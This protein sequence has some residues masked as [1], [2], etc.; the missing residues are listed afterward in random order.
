MVPWRQGTRGLS[1]LQKAPHVLLVLTVLLLEYFQRSGTVNTRVVSPVNLGHS[2][3][4]DMFLYF[5]S[6]NCLANDIQHPASPV[7]PVTTA[8]IMRSA[9]VHRALPIS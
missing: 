4:T 3:L 6:T 1:F 7:C 2:T 5:V 9:P 8:T